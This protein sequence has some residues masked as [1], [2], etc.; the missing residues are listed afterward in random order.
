MQQVA[1]LAPYAARYWEA[2]AQ[3][4]LVVQQCDTCGRLQLYP[5]V[6]C[7][8]CHGDELR[9]A[10]VS[11]EG[12]VYN[13]SVVYRPMANYAVP[14]PYIVAVVELTEGPRLTT[15]LV[16]LSP[17]EASIGMRVA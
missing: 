2:A 9:W 3:G 1:V 11:G 7:A 8:A 6:V 16:G 17:Q 10:G 15:R 5:R 4:V 12:S 14:V 13:Y